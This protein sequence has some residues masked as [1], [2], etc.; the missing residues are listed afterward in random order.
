MNHSSPSLALL[1]ALLAASLGLTGCADGPVTNEPAVQPEPLPEPQRSDAGDEVALPSST[2]V[3]DGDT[4]YQTAVT[5]QPVNGSA[6]RLQLNFG[7]EAQLREFPDEPGQNSTV[8]VVFTFAGEP[9]S[10]TYTFSSSRFLNDTD[11]DRINL[12][13]SHFFNQGTAR[14]GL[15][16][17]SPDS[18]EMTVSVDGA[19]FGA[20]FSDV[21]MSDEAGS[22]DTYQLS[23]DVL[24]DR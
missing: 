4:Y 19:T 11:T 24:A 12:Y 7:T 14:D 20:T 22:Q 15:N 5:V 1:A 21:T 16:F 9:S 18:G 10:G 3:L 6:Y 13:I 17:L 8:G 2:L 23:G